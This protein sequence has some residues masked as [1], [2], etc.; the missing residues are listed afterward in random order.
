MAHECGGAGGGIYGGC[1]C[2]VGGC[3]GFGGGG[4]VVVVVVV[5]VVTHAVG[6]KF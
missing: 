5:V 1:R 2:G 3:G 6:R 4:V